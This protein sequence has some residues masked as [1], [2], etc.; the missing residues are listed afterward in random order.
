MPKH[1]SVTPSSVKTRHTHIRTLTQHPGAFLIEAKWF[2]CFYSSNE[3]RLSGIYTSSADL[4][5]YTF[6]SCFC[7]VAKRDMW[8]GAELGFGTTTQHGHGL[9]VFGSQWQNT[10][11]SVG[12]WRWFVRGSCLCPR[13]HDERGLTEA[14]CPWAESVLCP[15]D[16][17]G[18]KSPDLSLLMQ[19]YSRCFVSLIQHFQLLIPRVPVSPL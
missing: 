19:L 18:L 12:G 8:K 14:I 17:A 5:T 16:A 10:E 13:Y 1:H 7:A 3:N 2:V 9:C 6:P 15:S 4:T 11:F